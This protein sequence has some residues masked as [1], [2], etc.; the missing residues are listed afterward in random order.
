M[1]L[2]W[3]EALKVYNAGMSSWTIPKKD[4]REMKEITKLR[5]GDPAIVDP[6][7]ANMTEIADPKKYGIKEEQ[8]E[9]LREFVKNISR[10]ELEVD[11]FDELKLKKKTLSVK[12][13]RLPLRYTEEGR[14]SG[15]WYITGK[16]VVIQIH[17]DIIEKIIVKSNQPN[18]LSKRSILA[19]ALKSPTISV[20]YK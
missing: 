20:K 8:L 17:E 14:K 19:D 7:P 13:P 16:N 5:H 2:S 3:F 6:K 4:S 15:A 18:P 11:R 12:F 10:D 9:A 1:A